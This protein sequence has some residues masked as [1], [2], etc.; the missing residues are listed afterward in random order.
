[1]LVVRRMWFLSLT[2]ID[3]TFPVDC[4]L[5]FLVKHVL[6]CIRST[7]MRFNADFKDDV[8]KE[9]ARHA[10]R[11]GRSLSDVVRTL[12]IKWIAEKRLEE[13]QILQLNGISGEVKDERGNKTD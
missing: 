4:R 8:Y 12:V 9:F 7:Q 1:M 13:L 2:V 3:Y 6:F 10:A 11:E 5:F